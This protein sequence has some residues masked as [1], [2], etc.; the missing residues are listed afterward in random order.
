VDGNDVL[1]VYET[2]AEA[3]ARAR[4]GE[5]P[6]FI[7]GKTCRQRAHFEGDTHL[8]R[9]QEDKDEC[10]K[11]DPILRFRKKLVEMGIF[12]EADADRVHQEVVAEVNEAEK[13]ALESPFP[14][15]KEVL[16][17]VFA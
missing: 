15:P 16:T 10:K 9:S 17:D 14:E 12:T 5:G 2:T 8:Y 11:R 13:F 4:R 3:V 1:A 6:T 7:E